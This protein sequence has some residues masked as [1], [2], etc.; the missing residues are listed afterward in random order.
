MAAV[1]P[2]IETEIEGH[3][4]PDEDAARLRA[5]MRTSLFPGG[6][7]LRPA[8]AMLDHAACGGK[9]PQIAR[10]AA[11]LELVHTFSLIHDDLPCMD[12]DDFRRGSPTCHRL[13]GEALAV[14][15]GDALL[16]LAYETLA[17]LRS[18][19]A[20]RIDVIA[21]L[22]RCDGWVGRAG[23]AGR[24]HRCGR[25]Q[26]RGERAAEHPSPQ[27]RQPDCGGLG[28]GGRAGGRTSIPYRGLGGIRARAW[29][30]LPDRGRY[31]ERRG[32][33]GGAGASQPGGDERRQKATY[34]SVVGRAGAH[35]R[36]R[37]RVAGS[38]RKRA[39]FR[40]VDRSFRRPRA[41]RGSRVRQAG[42]EEERCAAGNESRSIRTCQSR[43]AMQ[44][45]GGLWL[46][47]QSAD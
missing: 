12:D 19:P 40:R 11:S 23:R 39:G 24:R 14:L 44:Q 36:L 6:K 33:Y 20:R 2:S 15:A 34:P 35:A 41:G 25:S 32:E 31:P 13:Y 21:T 29:A 5:A 9:D 27:D 47:S 46:G 22:S 18:E 4:A 45:C 1:G 7:R 38:P 30:S 17:T 3:P 16:N 8:L 37:R 10:L 42:A 26:D 28:H 43:A